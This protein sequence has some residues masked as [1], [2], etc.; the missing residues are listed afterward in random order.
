MN[1][2]FPGPEY[3]F[4]WTDVCIAFGIYV[5]ALI[6]ILKHRRGYITPVLLFGLFIFPLQ[7]SIWFLSSKLPVVIASLG[8]N[9]LEIIYLLLLKLTLL[10]SLLMLK[11]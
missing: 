2:F 4:Y 7:F 9:F 5:L 6:L 11:R 8:I 1:S 10:F 3:Y